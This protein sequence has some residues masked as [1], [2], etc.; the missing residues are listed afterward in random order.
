M[1]QAFPVLHQEA[2]KPQHSGCCWICFW[3]FMLMYLCLLARSLVYTIS[4]SWE[5]LKEMPDNQCARCYGCRRQQAASVNGC[6]M[7]FGLSC[8]LPTC[9]SHLNL[10]ALL[11]ALISGLC[12]SCVLARIWAVE[13]TVE[14]T[15]DRKKNLNVFCETGDVIRLSVRW[16]P[17]QNM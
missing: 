1:V 16:P 14:W 4:T 3:V 9:C 5:V 8:G 15:H 17:L 12:M 13:G 7:N 2:W 10:V 6:V 11:L